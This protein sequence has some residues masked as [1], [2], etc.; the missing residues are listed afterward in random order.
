MTWFLAIKPEFLTNNLPFIEN[1]KQYDDLQYKFGSESNSL[2]NLIYGKFKDFNNIHWV[3]EDV[4]RNKFDH[5]DY[6]RVEYYTVLPTQNE[7][8]FVIYVK[9][10]NSYD[11]K[12]I[13]MFTYDEDVLVDQEWFEVENKIEF[14][15]ILS[16]DLN[17]IFY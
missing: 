1:S 14:Y 2:E 15:R 17:Q 3:H 16:L 4:A 10:S 13:E 12:K 8:E 6:S 5:K 9:I 11:S 7:N